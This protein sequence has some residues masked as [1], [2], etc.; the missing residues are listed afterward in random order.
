MDFDSYGE[1]TVTVTAGAKPVQLSDIQLKFTVAP[2]VAKYIVGMSHGPGVKLI[3][4]NWKWTNNS[5]DPM[6]WLGRIEAGVFLKLRGA[7]P[8]WE[9][10]NFSKDYPTIPF[11]PNS[12]GGQ[13]AN[14]GEFGCNISVAG[15]VLAFSGPRTSYSR[16]DV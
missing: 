3:D 4:T 1:Q 11:I 10:P 14:S 16:Q 15:A 12:W 7:G 13:Q 6:V 9:D 2:S 8:D 5:G